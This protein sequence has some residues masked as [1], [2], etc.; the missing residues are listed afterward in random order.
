MNR[1]A[2]ESGFVTPW[3]LSLCILL[4]I[5]GLLVFDIWKVYLTQRQLEGVADAASAG[6]AAQLDTARYSADSTVVIAA[7]AANPEASS[8]ATDRIVQLINKNGD[9]QVT[10]NSS[11]G[12]QY[13]SSLCADGA[14][15]V[16]AVKVTVQKPVDFAVLGWIAKKSGIIVRASSTASPATSGSAAVGKC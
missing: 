5:V 4:M 7:D 15:G 3:I 13:E 6:A 1:R 16:T 9:A 14:P 2:R 10:L 8:P 12:I 11:N